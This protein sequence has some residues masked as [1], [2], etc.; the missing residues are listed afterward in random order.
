[1]PVNETHGFKCRPYQRGTIPPV[2]IFVG[3]MMYH[4]SYFFNSNLL[5][6]RTYTVSIDMNSGADYPM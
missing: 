6:Y 5:I 2:L 1:M 4:T 3:C